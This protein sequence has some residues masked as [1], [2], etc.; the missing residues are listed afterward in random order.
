MLT[1]KGKYNTATVYTDN[2]TDSTVGQIMTLCNQKFTKDAKFELCLTLT[3]VPV[4]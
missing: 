2:L 3:A 1:I 4:V